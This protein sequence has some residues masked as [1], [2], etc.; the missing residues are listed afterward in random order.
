E[1]A[2]GAGRDAA[3]RDGQ[4]G[5]PGTRRG[6][7]DRA[8][9]GGPRGAGGRRGDRRR[10]R[11]GRRDRDGRGDGRRPG[12]AG[13]A[14]AARLGGQDVGAR[15]GPARGDRRLDRLP[16]RRHAPAA[17]ADRRADRSGVAGRPR[18]RRAVVPRRRV[19]RAAAASGVPRDDRLPLRPARDQRLAAVQAPRDDE[20][21]VR[22]RP[23]LAVPRGGRMGARARQDD[24]GPR[25]RARA[26]GAWVDDRLRE[27]RRPAPGADVRDRRRDVD[28]LGPLAHGARRHAA[29][30]QPVRPADAV[31]R[32]G[33]ADPA[34]APA[35][36]R[37][38]RR[39]ARGGAAVAAPGLQRRLPPAGP[40][41]LALPTRRRPGHGPA[42]A[43]GAPPDAHVARP[44]VRL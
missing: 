8:V 28:R 10:R 2:V 36:R 21:A 27:R 16:R 30:G 14:A 4:R 3:G 31:A 23:P 6:G 24:R 35:A 32:H 43:V 26:A 9:P 29:G 12:R 34:A 25:A 44:H 17:G 19:R 18:Q 22:R 7:T 39:R 11:V 42:H 33:A 20:R 37:R 40:G 1:A 15:A 38:A 5:D 41:L 13:H